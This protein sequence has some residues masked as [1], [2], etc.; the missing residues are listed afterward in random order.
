MFVPVHPA[1]QTQSVNAVLLR[2]EMQLGGQSVHATEPLLGLYFPAT[3]AE[4]LLFD[5]VQPASQTQ[6]VSDML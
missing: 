4:Q 5:P 2:T 1:L 6:A 3:Q